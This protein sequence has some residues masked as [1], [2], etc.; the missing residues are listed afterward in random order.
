MALADVIADDWSYFDGTETVTLRHTDLD[1]TIT[2]TANLTA[3]GRK[4]DKLPDGTLVTDHKLW[5]LKV[6]TLAGNTVMRRDQIITSED[7]AWIISDCSQQ[8]LNTKWNCI[9]KK[10][11]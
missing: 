10:S 2:N 9:S 11:L 4:L 6:S 5:I 1:G 3:L 8:A 7:I